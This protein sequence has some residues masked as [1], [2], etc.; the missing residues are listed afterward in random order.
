MKSYDDESEMLLMTMTMMNQRDRK[1]T[2]V[3]GGVYGFQWLGRLLLLVRLGMS[4]F[5]FV[6]FV[7]CW[8]RRFAVWIL[9]LLE[10]LSLCGICCGQ[11]FIYV[12]FVVFC[13]LLEQKL[14]GDLVELL[15]MQVCGGHGCLPPHS[16][17]FQTLEYCPWL[18]LLLNLTIWFP[19]TWYVVL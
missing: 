15:L 10:T 11:F 13:A 2:D 8:S 5:S 16:L 3:L 14:Q 4:N 12:F 17:L 18:V 6:C 7:H 19:C 1:D 9:V